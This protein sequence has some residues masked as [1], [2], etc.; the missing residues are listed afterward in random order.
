MK[1]KERF[2]ERKR[3]I[4]LS[5]SLFHWNSPTLQSEAHEVPPFRHWPGPGTI[6]RT[7]QPHQIFCTYGMLN[8]IWLLLQH[9]VNLNPMLLPQLQIKFVKFWRGGV[10]SRNDEWRGWRMKVVIDDREGMMIL[11]ALRFPHSVFRGWRISTRWK[12]SLYIC[13]VCFGGS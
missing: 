12:T 7:P 5:E 2:L 4:V 10:V 11:L 8:E 1:K 6:Q 3:I 9:C 13:F